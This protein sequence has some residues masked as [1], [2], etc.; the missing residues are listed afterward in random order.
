[1]DVDELGPGESTKV[2]V[3]IN[4]AGQ[5]GVFERTVTF[6]FRVHGAGIRRLATVKFRADV[7]SKQGDSQ[8]SHEDVRSWSECQDIIGLPDFSVL[9]CL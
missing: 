1:M 9:L 2:N 7:L 4:P 3:E 6:E 8:V 5:S